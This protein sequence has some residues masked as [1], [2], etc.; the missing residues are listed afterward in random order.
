MLHGIMCI[1]I[2]MAKQGLSL[3]ASFSYLTVSLDSNS[4]EH[5][6]NQILNPSV[7]IKLT[8]F[9]IYFDY[10]SF[11]LVRS[12]FSVLIRFWFFCSCIFVD[13]IPF[14]VIASGCHRPSNMSLW[15]SSACFP[16]MLG[17]LV[18]NW[19]NPSK[20][21]IWGQLVSPE[22]FIHWPVLPGGLSHTTASGRGQ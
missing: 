3:H 5:N 12:S 15:V 8:D 21:W 13:F 17:L 6:R 10:N 2:G 22:I 11:I 18:V 19:L 9:K 1:S 4:P 16:V 14:L 7:W 20:K